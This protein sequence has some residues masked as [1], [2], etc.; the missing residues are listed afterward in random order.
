LGPPPRGHRARA[1]G[2]MWWPCCPDSVDAS[3]AMIRCD[4]HASVLSTCAWTGHDI[5]VGEAA[6]RPPDD[7]KHKAPGTTPRRPRIWDAALASRHSV[8]DGGHAGPEAGSVFTA[9][10][11]FSQG[12]A[13]GLA[14]DV[15]QREYLRVNR[16]DR[17]G[18]IAE[19]NRCVEEWAHIR[20]GDCVVGVNRQRG[21]AM[22]QMLVINAG[23]PMDL[24]ILRPLSFTVTGLDKSKGKLGLDVVYYDFSTA[25]YIRSVAPAGLVRSHNEV[26]PALEVRDGDLI[27]AVNGQRGNSWD[28]VRLI[29]SADCLELTIS[30]PVA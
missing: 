23:G 2:A 27:I 15:T 8:A 1:P 10:V 18:P 21:D 4:D 5:A 12:Q 17:R 30:R 6:E 20:E 9:R 28:L 25:A 26:N 29:Q 24:E 3:V 22:E 16:V 13:L 7:A 19:Y 11:E 14:F